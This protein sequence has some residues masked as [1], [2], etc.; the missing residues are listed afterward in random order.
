YLRQQRGALLLTLVLVVCSSVLSVLGPYLLGQAIDRY[1]IPGDLPGLA[2]ICLAMLAVYGLNALVTWLQSYVLASAAQG[3][4]AATQAQTC[5]GFVGR[6]MSFGSTSGVA[7]VA[8]FG[9]FLAVQ[10][11]ATVGT[12]ASFVYY[13]REF[14]R[15]LNQIA[16]LYNT[17]QSAIAGA[18]RIFEMVD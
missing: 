14:G 18:E 7:L 17:I 10:G 15:P 9:V 11:L 8:G 2:R 12:I 1:V 4:V 16:T 5:A 3:T 6:V 13:S